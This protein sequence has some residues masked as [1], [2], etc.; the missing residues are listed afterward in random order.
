M[1]QL[2][3]AGRRRS[4]APAEQ[5]AGTHSSGSGAPQGEAPQ[6]RSGRYRYRFKS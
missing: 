4:G 6:G 2:V 3:R 1:S 5:A